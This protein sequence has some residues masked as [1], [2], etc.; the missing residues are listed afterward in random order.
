MMTIK[1]KSRHVVS[2][3]SSGKSYSNEERRIHEFVKCML[4]NR[5]FTGAFQEKHYVPQ[6]NTYRDI[7]VVADNERDLKADLCVVKKRLAKHY[8]KC[9][10]GVTEEATKCML[11]VQSS[12]EVLGTYRFKITKIRFTS[13]EISLKIKVV[14]N[15]SYT[16]STP[17]K[18]DAPSETVE[19]MNSDPITPKLK[20]ELVST[21]F[22]TTFVCVRDAVKF[23][24]VFVLAIIT[25]FFD[26]M[27]TMGDFV[28]RFV[29][30]CSL[31]IQA[32]TP[33]LLGCF[34]LIAKVVG[35]FY[36]LV[37]GMW[38][39]VVLPSPPP[40]YHRNKAKIGYR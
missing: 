32:F 18:C 24:I 38:R 31:C 27:P 25:A 9:W 3:N 22:R 11:W 33:L 1:S 23:I 21:S 36:L 2:P 40:M 19:S 26:A 4:L 16:I 12:A 35:G 39:A 14:E 17:R 10:V 5:I 37:L 34:D 8:E 29:H 15:V 13:E 28:I 20:I 7:V 30:E 6:L